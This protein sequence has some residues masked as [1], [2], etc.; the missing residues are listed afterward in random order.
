VNIA[1]KDRPQVDAATPLGRRPPLRKVD[2]VR[3]LPPP[4]PIRDGGRPARIRPVWLWSVVL[5]G[6]VAV[7]AAVLISV[8]LLKPAAPPALDT[9]ELTF[10]AQG[11][12]VPEETKAQD[13][14][15]AATPTPPDPTPVPPDPTPPPPDP[16]PPPPIEPPPPPMDAPPPVDTPPQPPVDDPPPPPPVKAVEEAMPIEAPPPP[17]TPPKVEP[18]K[19]AERQKP[20]PKLKPHPV[21]KEKTE[22]QQASEA[23]KVGTA[24]GKAVDQGMTRQTYTAILMAQ[25]REHRVRPQAAGN[26]GGTVVVSFTMTAAGTAVGISVSSSSGSALLDDAARQAVRAVHTP[27]PPGGSFSSS[28]NIHFASE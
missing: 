5:V 17:V 27:P 20:K 8:G 21:V 22:A 13:A 7:H 9:I 4:A 6:V 2:A 15:Q 3:A 1:L 10:V 19:P 18:T 11:D 26:V 24:D 14:Q 16:I 25:I 12:P 28:V 23:H